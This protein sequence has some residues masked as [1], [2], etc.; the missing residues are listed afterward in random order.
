MTKRS[1]RYLFTL[2]AT[3]IFYV[4]SYAY[5]PPNISAPDAAFHI[6]LDLF[7]KQKYE[8]AQFYMDIY[9]AT[10][11]NTLQAIEAS[12]YAAYCAVKLDR[13]DGEKRFQQFIEKYPY[14]PKTVLAYYE[15][16]NIYTT[17]QDYTKSIA[18]YLEADSTQ[19][20]E[21]LKT[22]LQYKIGYAYL[23]AKS[24]DEAL[25]Y[26]GRIKER[27]TPYKAVSNYYA[28]YL[29]LKKEDYENALIDLKKAGE[30]EVYETVVPYLIMEVLYK[31]KKFQEVI[32]YGAELDTKYTD[33]KNQPDITLLKAEAYFFLKNYTAAS[34]QYENCL[35]LQPIEATSEI[36]Y[37]LAYSLYK[38]GE[39][40][41]SLKYFKELA[42]Q[43]NLLAQLSSYYMGLTYLKIGQKNLA[44]AAFDHARQQDFLPE[45]QIEACFQYA[46]INYELGNLQKA[47]EI[48]EKFKISYPTS[49]YIPTVNNL[50]SQ[51]YIH[52]N[53]Y[54]LA[55]RHIEKSK[56]KSNTILQ[57]YQK[58]TFY[59]GSNCFNQ[60]DY[61]QAAIWLQKS[62]LYPY[63]ATITLQTHLWLAETYTEQQDYFAAI[64]QYEAIVTDTHQ[65]NT[66]YYQ[67]ALYGLGYAYFYTENYQ[68]ALH[69]F[70]EY[71]N[72]VGNKNTPWQ[73]DA[74][75]RVA[76]C[77]Y[78][79]KKYPNAIDF[80]NKATTDHIAHS[81]YQKALIYKIVNNFTAAQQN[82]E[83]IINFH[84][85]TNYYEKALFEYAKLAFQHEDYALGV[86]RFTNF[87]Q[88]KPHSLLIPDALLNRAIAYVNLK[89]YSEAGKDYET[90]LTNYPTH[91]N[92]QSALLELPKLVI[93]EGKPE[94]LQRYLA[95]YQA[96]NPNSNNKIEIITFETAKN[97]FYTQN[98]PATIKNLQEFIAKN[99]TSPLLDEAK[100]LIAEAYYRIG[101]EKQALVH[102]DI[103]SKKT[104][105]P[106]YHK[107]L[108]RV[109][110]IAYQQKDFKK[111]LE[112][113]T[114]LKEG[115]SN[116]KEAYY[117]L[118]GIMKASEGLQQYEEVN[119]AASLLIAQ[120][121]ITVNAVSQATL[122]LGKAAM[123]Q[124]K[125]GEAIAH[126]KEVTKSGQDIYAAEAQ[127]LLA[128]IYYQQGEY[129]QSL[130]SLFILNK[131][132]AKYTS[133]TNEG[134][135]LMADNY[136]AL[137]EIFQAR[138]TL[139]SIL[140]NTKD[141]DLIKLAQEKLDYLI[142]K[143][144]AD[145]IAQIV[146]LPP[147]TVEENNEFKTLDED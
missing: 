146:Q 137:G 142:Q 118:E 125:Q 58:A 123:Q 15:L 56:E 46:Q 4:N 7:Q 40:Y 138:A 84:S 131:Q 11:A 92:A 57:V 18:Y 76:D 33:L 105:T 45:M 141:A 22:E 89:Q 3:A 12:Y 83:N 117:A 115:T 144:E 23:S 95:G 135:L 19:L 50:L 104:Q 49:S 128:K 32:K 85:D 35:S 59:K 26:F 103:A 63:E 42:L 17:K 126:F 122:Y 79:M 67:D 120:G 13:A 72:F 60:E 145:S 53:D 65:Q 140:Q 37:R 143:A 119:K 147:A 34:K 30:N 25:D 113:Y 14:H 100:F 52:T 36:R 78:A 106:F 21:P 71:L 24:F 20:E 114:H 102:Y 127:Y 70:I 130:E 133:W 132:F 10:H 116:K 48:L 2:I 101:D 129:K 73:V 8:T 87:I 110:S 80:Y 77:Y 66:S 27:E 96:A 74:S 81:Y 5:T 86:R 124:S 54:D 29:A 9:A 121:N 107:I 47:I 111:A 97:L 55:I 134:F 99:P 109:A 61:E 98:Y 136:I 16:G 38:S 75:I 64:P 39:G 28:G 44:L 91:P 41:K 51:V 1:L 139:Q 69:V 31:A 112:N 108:L 90:L 93:Q 82:L 68:K 62:L 6:G 94:K 43:N 88:K